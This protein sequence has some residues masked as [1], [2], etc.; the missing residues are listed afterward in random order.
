MKEAIILIILFF[1][2]QIRIRY[3]CIK[4]ELKGKF[5]LSVPL[6]RSHLVFSRAKPVKLFGLRLA[7]TEAK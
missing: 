6:S 4:L 7:L 5:L 2:F 3:V 1:R